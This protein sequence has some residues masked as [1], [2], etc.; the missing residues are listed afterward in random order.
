M[1]PPAS[2]GASG[3]PSAGLTASSWRHEAEPWAGPGA[4]SALQFKKK[5]PAGLLSAALQP[6]GHTAGSGGKSA[7]IDKQKFGRP[8]ATQH[9]TASAH[10]QRARH[11]S[12]RPQ[13]AC[14]YRQRCCWRARHVRYARAKPASSAS[15]AFARARTPRRPA[16]AGRRASARTLAPT[17]GS[18][19]KGETP[20]RM[21]EASRE[22][23][24]CGRRAAAPRRAGRA[25][26]LQQAHPQR[27]A[28]PAGPLARAAGQQLRGHDATPAN[29]AL[30]RCLPPSQPVEQLQWH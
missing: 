21:G 15:R 26:A 22:V 16:S 19:A 13:Q 9:G 27:L 20:S 5:V 3:A 18:A 25:P 28:P 12:H 11:A 4:F 29:L 14:A 17:G 1:E 8:G 24:S 7:C 30:L 6:G 23:R 10:G 2:T